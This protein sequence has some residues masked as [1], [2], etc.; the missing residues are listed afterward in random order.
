MKTFLIL[1]MVLVLGCA[2]SGPVGMS[3]AARDRLD[4]DLAG[5]TAGPPQ[6]CV[7]NRDLRSSRFVGDSI[8]YR[9]PGSLLYLNRTS[10]GCNARAGRSLITVN[11]TGNLCSGDIVRSVDPVS[12][13][14][15]G[16]CTLGEFVPYRRD[17]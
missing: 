11:P 17:R 14:D 2:A 3:D 10:G 1:P 15:W 12:G 8:V 5:R 9:G 7:S 16:S 6:S 13:T 4:R